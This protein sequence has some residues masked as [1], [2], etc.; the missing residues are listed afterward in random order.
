MGVQFYFG[1][2]KMGGKALSVPSARISASEYEKFVDAV[3]QNLKLYGVEG[4]P[5]PISHYFNKP[6]FGDC[7]ILVDMAP[8][9]W[10]RFVDVAGVRALRATEQVNNGNVVSFG[11]R[12]SQEVFQVDFIN[13]HGH[14]HWAKHYFG[15]NDLGNLIGRIAHKLGFK[16]GQDG[17]WYVL[18]DEEY[19][20]RVIAEL[21][22]TRDIGKA[23]ELLGYDKQLYAE[24]ILG[25]FKEL[26]DIFTFVASTPY[27]NP[28][29]YLLDNRNAKARVRD[30]KR[31][32]YMAF[33][34]WC[35]KRPF[36]PE[37]Q[38]AARGGSLLRAIDMFPEFGKELAEAKE[39]HKALTEFKRNWN[40]D[41]VGA[42][43][44]YQGPQLGRFLNWIKRQW[45]TEEQY[46]KAILEI[47]EGSHFIPWVKSM[48]SFF[49]AELE[50]SKND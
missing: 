18:R 3:L 4:N 15:F 23:L 48:K 2:L 50:E 35:A 32:T 6:D 47:K 7:D 28:N 16:F 11:V 36:D 21:L 14:M 17:L 30:S 44:Q 25:D 9:E 40:G 46:R 34:E 24:G 49:E 41:I 39:R 10:A 13:A 1:A 20:S 26:E 37:V 45:S 43:T 12:W 29:I 38:P 42:L 31:K 19:D 27:F 8:E 5:T 33:L 22:I